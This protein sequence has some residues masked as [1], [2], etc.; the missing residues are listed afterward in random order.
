MSVLG[1]KII[2]IANI[3]V[4]GW[5]GINSLFFPKNASATIFS[6]SYAATEVIRLVGSLWTGIAA[7]SMFGLWQPLAFSPVL[8]L[9]LIYKGTW[10]LFV[11]VPAIRNQQSYPSGM[12]AFFLVWVLVLPFII[13][14]EQWMH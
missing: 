12:A 11:A 8:F 1:L 4:A 13:P 14:W 3:L 7:L 9:Q 10:L 2:Y 5:I 6:G